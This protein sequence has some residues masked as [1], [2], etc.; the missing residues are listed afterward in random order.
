MAESLTTKTKKGVFWLGMRTFLTQGFRIGTSIIIARL[1]F[2]VDFGLMSLA[3]IAV[4]FARR[5]GEFGFIL[6]LVQK[7]EISEE[8]IKT[9]FSINILLQSFLFL[10]LFLS[11]DF[12]A[13]LLSNPKVGLI[14]RLLSVVFILKSFYAIPFALLRR[15]LKY[16]TISFIQLW[17]NVISLTT[18][19]IFA[20]FHWGVWSLVAGVL[21]SNLFLTV[22]FNVKYPW[23]PHWGFSKNCFK[24]I[25]SFGAWV[26][27]QTYLKYFINNVDYFFVGKFLGA[28]QLGYYERAFDLMNTP[29]KR[30]R[31]TAGDVLFSVYSRIQD[32]DARLIGALK[33][34]MLTISMI[35]YPVLAGLY[36]IA[37]SF[38]GALYGSKWIPAIKPLQIMCIS[39]LV[40]SMTMI[41]DPILFARGFLKER[42]IL[43][44]VYFIVLSSG[45]VIGLKWGIV[46]VSWA[47]VVSSLIF[48]TMYLAVLKRKIS[49][50]YKIFF[51]YQLKAIKY[52][53]MMIIIILVFKYFALQYIAEYTVYM[54]LGIIFSG[55]LGLFLAHI[56]FRDKDVV[57]ILD[58]ILG[59]H[60]KRYKKYLIIKKI[61]LFL[62]I[63]NE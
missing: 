2:P 17:G 59:K 35:A 8:H 61:I 44:L 33:K 20:L 22:A 38:V 51:L 34:V 53:L 11:A 27:F 58:E 41:Y 6:V 52:T 4:R 39:G 23:K 32:D 13:Y 10:V 25:F 31:D 29:R 5:V 15:N 49:L 56:I 26:S 16:K 47:V 18:P 62:G 48:L 9:T 36:F 28:T 43:F 7:K 46:G 45:V 55:I 50:S 19:I 60:L 24:D 57:L 63:P 3:M 1:L 14:L 54:L 21:L 30:L 37:P 12:I 42:T 40:G